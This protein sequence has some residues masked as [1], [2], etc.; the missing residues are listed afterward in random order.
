M[1]FL[2]RIIQIPPPLSTDSHPHFFLGVQN[3]FEGLKWGFPK[4]IST[5]FANTW[6]SLQTIKIVIYCCLPTGILWKSG[7]QAFLPPPLNRVNGKTKISK[8]DLLAIKQILYDICQSAL[9]EG[10]E[11]L[12]YHLTMILAKETPH[13]KRKKGLF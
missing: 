5:F 3:S 2:K 1:S 10:L 9:P 12:A 11:V 4:K 13:K 7:A 6:L 8:N